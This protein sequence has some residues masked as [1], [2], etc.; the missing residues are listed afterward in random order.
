MKILIPAI[1]LAT[2][3]APTMG[4]AQSRGCDAKR[5]SIQRELTYA[6][7]HHD[8][9]RVQGLQKALAEMNAHCTDVSLRSAAQQKV[10]EAQKKLA[11]RQHEL[12]Q[13]QSQG[14]SSEKIVARQRKVADAHAELEQA[15]MDAASAP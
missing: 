5:Q 8:A 2:F 15:M 9:S 6:R 4:W 7:A 13:A 3:I 1:L 11:D 14:K 10:T 12:Q